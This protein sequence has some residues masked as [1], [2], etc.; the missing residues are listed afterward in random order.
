[1]IGATLAIELLRSSDF[2]DLHVRTK[3]QGNEELELGSYLSFHSDVDWL[4]CLSSEWFQLRERKEASW[5]L[6]SM[7][8]FINTEYLSSLH[9][10]SWI[11]KANAT[12]F[13]QFVNE[14]EVYT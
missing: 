12:I 1:V 4:S 6:I 7:F 10:I 9:N 11:K 14:I 3:T 5:K 2:V 13:F 8:Q